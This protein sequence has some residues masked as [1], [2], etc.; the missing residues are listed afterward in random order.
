MNVLVVAHVGHWVNSLLY[1]VPVALVTVVL[2]ISTSRDRRR[3]A[4]HDRPGTAA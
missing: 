3:D 4:D 1:T 2:A